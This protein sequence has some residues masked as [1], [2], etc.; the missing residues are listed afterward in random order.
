MIPTAKLADVIAPIA[1]SAPIDLRRA[2][3]LMKSAATS[4]QSPAPRK[5]FTPTM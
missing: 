1:A 2:T 4:P 3:L 5:T